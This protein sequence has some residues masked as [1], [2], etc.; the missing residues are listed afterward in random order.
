MF[1]HQASNSIG[2]E[3]YNAY[4]YRNAKWLPHL[5]KAYELTYVV[6]GTIKATVAG[7]EYF[8]QAGEYILISPYQIHAYDESNA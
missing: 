7:K 6:S 1:I 3:I 5:H 4:L 2:D 8:L